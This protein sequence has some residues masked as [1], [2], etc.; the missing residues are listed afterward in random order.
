MEQNFPSSTAPESILP[1]SIKNAVAA[2]V[3]D[4]GKL[5]CLKS[6][7]PDKPELKIEN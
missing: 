4:P 2:L 6:R 3:Y 1:S 7:N 5:T